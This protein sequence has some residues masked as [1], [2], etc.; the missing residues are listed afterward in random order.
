VKIS[1]ITVCYNSVSTI[2][3][4]LRS[5]SSQS[6][7]DIEHLVIDGLST[8][9]T[10]SQVEANRHKNLF[11]TSEAD[12]GIYDAMNKGL[13]RATGDIIG[14]LNADDV[15]ADNDVLVRVA[16][17]FERDSQLEICFGDLVYVSSDNRKIVRYCKS[18]PFKYG[19]FAFGWAP[20]H[21][22]FY[23]RRSALKQMGNFDLNYRL[24]ADADFMMRYLET[25]KLRSLYLPYV[26]VRM[27]VGGVS[28]N[29]LLN[30]FR[31]NCEIIHAF[32]KNNIKYSILKFLVLKFVNRVLQRMAA[33]NYK[34]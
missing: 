27:R 19:S 20:A 14:F 23:I 18:K 22:T 9:Q 6:H 24:A 26:Q 13:S 15:F 1:I 33:V 31:Q 34:A 32:K 28:N 12:D 25:G 8:D 11:L 10:I 2:A 7:V 5:V 17:A 3:D 29:S 21:P 4:T 30:I 16:K